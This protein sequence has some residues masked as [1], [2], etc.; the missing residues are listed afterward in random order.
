MKKTGVI[1]L[2][3]AGVLWGMIGIVVRSMAVLG[4]SGMDIVFVRS[5]VTTAFLFIFLLIK[6][7]SL[8]KINIKDIWI[9]AGTGILSVVF[10]NACYFFSMTQM[11]LSAA[12]VLMYTAP[13]FAAIFS[14][15]FFKENI[16][17]EKVIAII[18]IIL[19]C[20]FV[21]G[22]IGGGN[23]QMTLIGFLAGI[24]AG[25]GYS[26]YSIFGKFAIKRNYSD[27]TILFYTFLMGSLGSFFL[28]NPGRDIALM[29]SSL[30]SIIWCLILGVIS[31]FLPFFFY[32]IGLRYVPTS[33]ASV[34][35]SIEPV[36][37]TLTGAF[38]YNEKIALLNVLGIALVLSG[39]A[40]SGMKFSRKANA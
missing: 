15:I 3:L 25:V 27:F 20:C 21:T 40:I 36:V 33:R 38:F 24:G 9:F 6:D 7:K 8:L 34:I 35:S 5:I 17:L 13:L 26:L 2:L 23:Q 10:F 11:S 28:V 14:R 4:F 37:A 30:E 29:F 1:F 16:T 39:I 19:G 31:T 32:T 18:F 12:C 22:L